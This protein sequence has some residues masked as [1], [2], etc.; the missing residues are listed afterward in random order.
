MSVDDCRFV[1]GFPGTRKIAMRFL[2]IAFIL[3]G[4]YAVF[5][6]NWARGWFYNI[7]G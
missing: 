6:H 7:M 3:V 4:A 1:D 5:L 2:M